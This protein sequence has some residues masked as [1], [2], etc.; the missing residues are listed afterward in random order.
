MNSTMEDQY[1]H[2][3][4]KQLTLS[5]PEKKANFHETLRQLY[6]ASNRHY[7]NLSH[8]KAL[9][10]LTA[11]YQDLL[12]SPQILQFTIWYHD[13]IYNA[14]KG[15]NE[16]K[17][18]DLA[19]DHLSQLGIDSTSIA[20]VAE[21]IRATKTHQLTEINDS[22]E[23][24]FML[25]IDLS[26]LACERAEYLAYTKQIRKEYKVYPDIIYNP[27]RKKVLIHFLEMAN[28][29]KT[30]IF[31]DKWEQKAKENLGYELSLL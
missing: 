27:G 26:I 24:R 11:E 12:Q 6:T 23:A 20:T 21:I 1:L 15:D 25:D 18:A 22:F 28:I 13:A 31:R 16:E 3:N 30:D 5:L 10:L 8:I 17:S 7:H 9:L 2:K 14:R 19:V 29:Y 4:W